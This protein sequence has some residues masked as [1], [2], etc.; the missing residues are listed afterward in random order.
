VLVRLGRYPEVLRQ[1]AAQAEPS[2]LSNWLLGLARELNSWYVEHRV[3]GVEPPLGAA[4]LR[5]IECSKLVLAN[6]L[7]LL[8]IGAPQEM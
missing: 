5:L 6:G 3:L 8:G 4:R 2:V 7:Q 1:A